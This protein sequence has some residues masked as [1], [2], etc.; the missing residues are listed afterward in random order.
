MVLPPIL[1]TSVSVK[2]FGQTSLC[3]GT[4]CNNTFS[5]GSTKRFNSLTQI[6][7]PGVTTGHTS[8]ETLALPKLWDKSI[9]L[10]VRPCFFFSCCAI[11]IPYS[12]CCLAVAPS[13]AEGPPSADPIDGRPECDFI[14]FGGWPR[15]AAGAVAFRLCPCCWLC[16]T[17]GD[18]LGI[19][20]LT[21]LL[22]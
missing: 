1:L 11:T 13:A 6:L 15:V 4:K 14:H 22:R 3:I 10:P 12:D 16:C 18:E 20:R 19:M 7:E 21:K 2:A 9:T 5:M 8:C 17:M